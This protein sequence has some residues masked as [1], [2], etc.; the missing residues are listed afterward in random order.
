[1]RAKCR[2]V[3]RS[4]GVPDPPADK[5]NWFFKFFENFPRPPI[6]DGV[7]ERLLSYTRFVTWCGARGI[8]TALIFH[9]LKHKWVPKSRKNGTYC[10]SVASSILV[11]IPYLRPQH[12]K[13]SSLNGGAGAIL[14]VGRWPAATKRFKKWYLLFF[15]AHFFLFFSINDA[16]RVPIRF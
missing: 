1:M 11:T 12:A 14:F 2:R 10:F 16:F 5:K 13:Y 3:P 4:D 8:E 9:V 15:S 6:N 7:W